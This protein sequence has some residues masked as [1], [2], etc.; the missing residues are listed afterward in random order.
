MTRSFRK[1]QWCPNWALWLAWAEWEQ[2]GHASSFILWLLCLGRGL[3]AASHSN[4]M[5]WK[6]RLLLEDLLIFSKEHSPAVSVALLCSL[7]PSSSD[8]HAGWEMIRRDSSAVS[9]ALPFQLS[10][11]ADHEGNNQ[12]LLHPFKEWQT[13]FCLIFKKNYPGNG[14]FSMF[15]GESCWWIA[16]PSGFLHKSLLKPK[17]LEHKV[18][19]SRIP[20]VRH[21]SNLH[22]AQ[23]NY[24]SFQKQ[25]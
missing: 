9:R 5:Q 16:T 6:P 23:E 11:G 10:W 25:N 20:S 24:Q 7:H 1:W 14:K 8:C 13:V 12:F 18:Q 4:G 22:V 3:L 21:T 19:S 2:S 17:I 15:T